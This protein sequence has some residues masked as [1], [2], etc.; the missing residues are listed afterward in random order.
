M[1][2]ILSKQLFDWHKIIHY[3][4]EISKCI[5]I[6]SRKPV[7][8]SDEEAYGTLKSVYKAIIS[9]KI[10]ILNLPYSILLSQSFHS[11]HVPYIIRP[12]NER[13]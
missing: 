12:K 10:A 13:K 8:M 6:Y 7:P 11:E 9:S 4:N 2:I 5:T 1:Y 3:S